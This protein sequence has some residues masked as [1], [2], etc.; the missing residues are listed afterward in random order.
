MHYSKLELQMY[1]TGMLSAKLTE[2][3]ENH[4]RECDKCLKAYLETLENNNT[5]KEINIKKKRNHKR[6]FAILASFILAFTVFFQTPI[7]NKVMASIKHNFD[8]ITLSLS[9][10]F[11][12]ES[13]DDYI[14]KSNLIATSNGIS[15]QLKEYT[16][17][18][19]SIRLLFLLK[20][21]GISSRDA[22]PMG[23]SFY[24]NGKEPEQLSGDAPIDNEKD[25]GVFP[26]T[27]DFPGNDISIDKDD[28]FRVEFDKVLY[29]D[30][31]NPS[32][33]GS[34]IKG[35]WIFEFTGSA[36]DLEM[37][38]K[39]FTL[40]FKKKVDSTN[41]IVNHLKVNKMY[42]AF[43]VNE[44]HPVSRDY[45]RFLEFEIEDD[46][47][48][49]TTARPLSMVN[50]E[51]N[52]IKDTVHSEHHY[53]LTDNFYENIKNSKYLKIN[54]YTLTRGDKRAEHFV[55]DYILDLK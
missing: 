39:L 10:A 37:S 53:K 9:E 36:K 49:I 12:F 27:L 25:F 46:K 13:D 26:L 15:I 24:I 50:G 34:E 52:V 28:N 29:Y 33:D 54:I 51:S 20:G 18:K 5:V 23:L 35:S 19:N 38:Q 1:R 45:P 42:Q 21:E 40:D 11:G 43:I 2:E 22:H 48:N 4:L 44:K 14:Y 3:I 41:F 6:T 16:I 47:G 17:E 31:E 55:K 30:N 32:E 8:E 7:G